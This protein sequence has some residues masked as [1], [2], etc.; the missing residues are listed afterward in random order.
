MN[1]SR[2]LRQLWISHPTSQA[3]NLVKNILASQPNPLSTKQIY[4][5]AIAQEP[6]ERV[7]HWCQPPLRVVTGNE[8][9]QGKNKLKKPIPAPPHPDH[10]IRSVRY[11]CNNSSSLFHQ[12][13]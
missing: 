3:L 13:N 1:V 8:G 7:E 9:N 5:L 2:V 6:G 11:V 10:P 12:L 4:D